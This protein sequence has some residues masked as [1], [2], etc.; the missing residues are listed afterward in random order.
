[1]SWPEAFANVA[2]YTCLA[3]V[4]VAFLIGLSR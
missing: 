4:M 2:M 3:V 1:M